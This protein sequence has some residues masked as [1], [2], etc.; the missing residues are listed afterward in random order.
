[1]ALALLIASLAASILG[2]NTAIPAATRNIINDIYLAFS[3]IVKSGVT[4][5]VSPVTVLAALSG[6]IQSIKSIPNLPQQTLELVAMLD[7]AV[8]DALVADAA[9][10]QK[11]DALLLQP[12]QPV[13]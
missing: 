3:A 10:Q 12:I 4:T 6:V 13:A 9:A 8:Q 7:A 1:M 11:V 5:K 2:Q